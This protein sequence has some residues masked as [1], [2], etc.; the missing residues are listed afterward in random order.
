MCQ[1]TRLLD[2]D[3]IMRAMAAQDLLIM[4][5]A[6]MPYLR[7][8]RKTAA[9]ELVRAIDAISAQIE[10]RESAWEKTRPPVDRP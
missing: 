7:E 5:R 4:G 3:P 8:Q 9:P 6:A 2:S 10:E 1:A